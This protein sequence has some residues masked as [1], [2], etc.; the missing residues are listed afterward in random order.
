[1]YEE[2][3]DKF[4]NE[5]EAIKQEFVS[6]HWNMC[7]HYVRIYVYICVWVFVCMYVG[8]SVCVLSPR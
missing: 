3:K 2:A 5:V 8:I 6:P 7:V 4:F 1:M